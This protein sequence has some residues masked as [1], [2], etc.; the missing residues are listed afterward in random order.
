[1]NLS[2]HLVSNHL[3]HIHGVLLD[4]MARLRNNFLEYLEV[5]PWNVFWHP[6]DLRIMYLADHFRHLRLRH[7]NKSLFM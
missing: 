6:T 3:W 7:F 1:M 5:D 4:Q 2:L